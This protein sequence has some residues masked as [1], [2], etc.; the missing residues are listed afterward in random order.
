M[1][2]RAT[3]S[4]GAKAYP[5]AGQVHRRQDGTW[6]GKFSYAPLKWAVAPRIG[7]ARLLTEDGQEWLISV[8]ASRR[9]GDHF[10]CA[11]R[12]VKGFL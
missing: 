1:E 2:F 7:P 3:L 5:V 10:E 9:V 8:T 6:E 11:F 4:R 12:V